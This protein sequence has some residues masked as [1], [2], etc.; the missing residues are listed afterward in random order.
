MAKDTQACDKQM[1]IQR[2]GGGLFN[3]KIKCS[4]NK[5]R[6]VEL[7]LSDLHFSS[8][9]PSSPSSSYIIIYHH[10]HHPHHRHDNRHHHRHHQLKLG[11]ICISVHCTGSNIQMA[12][13]PEAIFGQN[14]PTF[15]CDLIFFSITEMTWKLIIDF[16]KLKNSN[17]VKSPC[18]I[19]IYWRFNK[20]E[21]LWTS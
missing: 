18:H 8:S 17:T 9:S 3:F 11:L 21:I 14:Y 13:A 10:P 16:I 12:T 1:D 7:A 15:F 2:V 19:V 5:G 4:A 20:A 6:V